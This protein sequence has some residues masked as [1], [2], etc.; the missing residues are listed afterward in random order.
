[1]NILKYF[2]P[3][4]RKFYGMFIKV[5]DN[6]IE[7]SDEFNKLIVAPTSEERKTIGATIKS[8]ERKGDD[9]T[10]VIMEELH[11]TFITPFDRE[12]IAKLTSNL[13]DVLDLIY[14]VSGKMEYYH[15]TNISTYMKDMVKQIQ[16]GCL[17]I[18]V[19]VYGLEKMGKED[20]ILKAC[21]E[22]SRIESKVDVIFHEAISNLFE[23]EKDAIELIKQKEVL[24]NIEKVANK[25]EDVS[26]VIKTI[27]IK[28]N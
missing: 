19:A 6:L 21:K 2:A 9:L 11:K 24:L 8:I 18:Q 12:D 23:N 10:N 1:M 22:L 20:I 3:K 25:I 7:A 13:D 16:Q 4:E 26:K 15:F 28:Y 14:G 17:Q 5:A 27:L